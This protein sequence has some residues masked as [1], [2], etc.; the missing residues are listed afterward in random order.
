MAAL[1]LLENADVKISQPISIFAA[2]VPTIKPL[3][4]HPKPRTSYSQAAMRLN[5]WYF[6]NAI[7][8]LNAPNLNNFKCHPKT[9]LNNDMNKKSS[10]SSFNRNNN[11]RENNQHRLNN[12][13]LKNVNYLPSKELMTREGVKELNLKPQCYRCGEYSH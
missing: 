5:Y 10:Q 13:T 3:L 8:Q 7:S 9:H 6:V 1:L 2:A 12:I 4:L 11:P